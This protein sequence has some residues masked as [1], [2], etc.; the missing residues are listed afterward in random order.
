MQ[1]IDLS[2][3]LEFFD[4][5]VGFSSDLRCEDLERFERSVNFLFDLLDEEACLVDVFVTG[6]VFENFPDLVKK[7][8]ATGHNVGFHSI[9]HS[10]FEKYTAQDIEREIQH[11]TKL[12]SIFPGCKKM[13]RVPGFKLPLGEARSKYY[14]LISL[15]GIKERSCVKGTRALGR[16]IRPGGT[17]FRIT[18]VPVFLRLFSKI[19]RFEVYVHPRDV[20]SGRFIPGKG[21][22]KQRVIAS[23]SFG[24]PEIKITKIIKHL[25][26]RGV[27]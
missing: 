20:Y 16:T 10:N 13:M 27:E 25:K 7:I 19:T 17:V 12:M 11:Y 23:L 6:E 1:K 18:P 9:N 24:N 21:S 4:N 2:I 26:L 15:H 5:L 14:E 8:I 22:F 3:D